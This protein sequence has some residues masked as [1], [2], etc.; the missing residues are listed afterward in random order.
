MTVSEICKIISDCDRLRVII[1][2]NKHEL[3]GSELQEI[4]NLLWDYRKEL[5]SKEVK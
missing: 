1:L 2:Q 5:L 4:C 3:T